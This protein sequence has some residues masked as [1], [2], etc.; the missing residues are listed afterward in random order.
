[1]IGKI[2]SHYRIVEMLG[3]GGMGIVYAADDT[4]LGRRV[5]IKLPTIT[6][7]Q[8]HF[9]ARFLREA[10]AISNL[11]HPH[12]A[13]IYD[14]GETDEGQPYIVMEL[15]TGPTLSA[16]MRENPLTLLRAVE[17]IRDIAEAL[18][19]AHRHGIIHRDIKPS[20]VLLNQ[21]Q[22]VKVLDFGLAKQINEERKS[23]TDPEAK[24]LLATQTRSGVIVGTP[25]YLSPEQ[26]RSAPVDA[27]SDIFSLGALLYECVTGSPAFAA[28]DFLDIAFKIVHSDPSPP[29]ELNPH[30]PAELDRIILKAL[31]KDPAARYQSAEDLISDLEA[32]RDE[33]KQVS[34]QTTQRVQRAPKTKGETETTTLSDIMRRPRLS[35]L[36]V[37]ITII[38]ASLALGIY[39]YFRHQPLH[40]PTAEAQRWYEMGTNALRDGAYYQASN[41]LQRAIKTDPQ[42]PLAHARY[43]EAL[44][45][46][47][48]IS[49]ARAE[50]LEADRYIPDR[51]ALPQ[52]DQLR[53][54]AITATAR[55][56]FAGALKAYQEITRLTPDKAEAFVD[57]GRAYE[58]AE[59]IKNAIESYIKAADLEKQSPT[60]L[61]RVGILYGRQKEMQSANAAF[62]KA[63]E[64]Y[65]A[66]GSVE[67]R[68]QVHYQRGFMLRDLNKI[69]EAHAELQ[70]SYDLA[71]TTQN[72]P[73]QILSL[74]QLSTV[75]F[76]EGNTS[77]AEQSAREAVDLAQARGMESLVARGLV[78]LGSAYFIHGKIDEAEKYFRQALDAAH[79]YNGRRYEARALLALGS[80]LIQ[81]GATD[82]GLQA[83]EQALDFYQQGGYR[84]QVAQCSI[85]IGRV[86][87]SKGDFTGAMQAFSEQLQSAEQFGDKAQ[88]SKFHGE[89]GNV[90]AAQEKFSAAL[91]H[92][93][94][95]YDI[96]ES[97]G[98]KSS[99]GY[100]LLNR[101]HVLWQMGLYPEASEMLGQATAIADQ[102]TG[103]FKALLSAIYRTEAELALSQ[104]RF[105]VAQ[106]KIQQALTTAGTP[107]KL[108]EVEAKRVLG[109]AESD[110]GQK[111]AGRQLCEEALAKAR[112]AGDDAW[113]SASLLSLAQTTLEDGDAASAH[114]LALQAQAQFARGGQLASEWLAWLI[115][116]RAS[117]SAGE[118]GKARA[119]ALESLNRLSRL[120]QEWGPGDF[121]AYLKRPDIQL[122]RKQLG[123]WEPGN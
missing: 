3:E 18:A 66:Q 32:V 4:L 94:Q 47:D 57:L 61:L 105:K 67:G 12:I 84:T 114:E 106:D 38:T 107:D 68:A 40:Q 113:I 123:E 19:E 109:L 63:Y 30:V 51:S 52:L 17:I 119:E 86:K 8:H 78:D 43:A 46:L 98:D 116:A 10:R 120:Q 7:N 117:Q 23:P 25:L 93:K 85:L 31:A 58:S 92:F 1:M 79:R 122:A 72:E 56:D 48:D 121:N 83:V 103:G 89:I 108:L 42:F 74:L 90:L 24:T 110:S 80:L 34:H 16:V 41:M 87:Q 102:P 28:A 60:P 33:L 75:S 100:S 2:I 65:N 45:E 6:S 49:K 36:A 11:S 20:N 27:R 91:D 76:A 54:A 53:L 97:L 118:T 50:L 44:M 96:A 73:Q 15:V 77:Q 55:R 14:Y 88:V 62:D 37:L 35:F 13:T 101:G 115:A 39:L 82:E 5:A 104:R 69:Q 22:E 112:Q 99:I 111:Q 9:R 95:K 71:R 70:K 81:K 59:D 64:L 26:A 21:R 29:S